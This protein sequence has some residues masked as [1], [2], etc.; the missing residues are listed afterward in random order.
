MS[1]GWLAKYAYTRVMVSNYYWF[2][3]IG[4]VM[5]SASGCLHISEHSGGLDLAT[6]SPSLGIDYNFWHI[7][8]L[9]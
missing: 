1:S 3:C 9:V 4:L 8:L 5:A 6:T 2:L 7:V